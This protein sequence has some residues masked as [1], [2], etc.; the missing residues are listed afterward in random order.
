[1]PLVSAQH[2]ALVDDRHAL[3]APGRLG[4]AHMPALLIKGSKSPE[5]AGAIVDTLAGRMPDAHSVTIAGARHMSPITHPE[6]VGQAILSF[7]K[8]A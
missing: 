4:R 8:M 7:L 3:L 5:I 1:M 2:S 6:A